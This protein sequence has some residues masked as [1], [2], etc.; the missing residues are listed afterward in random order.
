MCFLGYLEIQNRICSKL[1]LKGMDNL[2]YLY[3]NNNELQAL[4][5]GMW[6]GLKELRTLSVAYNKISIIAT[7]AFDRLPK[8]ETL[9]LGG[10]Y[11]LGY[12]TITNIT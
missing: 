3:I 12:V 7:G 9:Y 4:R 11:T 6:R 10:T 8:L 2:D 1:Y 5:S